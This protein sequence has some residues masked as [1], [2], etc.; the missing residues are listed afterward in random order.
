MPGPSVL[1]VISRG[2]TLGRAGLATVVGNTAGLGVELLAVVVGLGAV[3]ERSIVAFTVVKVAGA[4][5]L[6]YLGVQAV[7]HRRRLADAF[8]AGVEPKGIGRICREGFLVGVTNPKSIIL[9]TAQSCLSS[10]IR[11]EGT[12]QSSCWCSGSPVS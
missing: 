12:C 5:Y 7:R 3:V 1:F 10:P 11:P 9:F 6:V 8:G 4:V 2:V